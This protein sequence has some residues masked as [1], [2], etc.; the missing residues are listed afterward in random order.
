MTTTKQVKIGFHGNSYWLLWH[1]E[2]LTPTTATLHGSS[3]Y[4]SGPYGSLEPA[5]ATCT[6]KSQNLLHSAYRILPEPFR[7]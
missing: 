1:W 7:P 3:T 4:V 5:E 2:V 6:V